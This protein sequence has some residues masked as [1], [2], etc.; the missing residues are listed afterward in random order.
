MKN[1]IIVYSKS[2][3]LF[4]TVSDSSKYKKNTIKRIE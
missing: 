4:V 3:L 2:Q 1:L